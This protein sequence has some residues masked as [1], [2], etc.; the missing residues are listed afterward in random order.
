M[1]I[2][3]NVLKKINT[4]IGHS[5]SKQTKKYTPHQLQSIDNQRLQLLNT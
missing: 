5:V 2:E 4:S 3:M 1:T